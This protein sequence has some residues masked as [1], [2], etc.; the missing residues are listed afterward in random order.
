MKIVDR[1][2]VGHDLDPQAG[3][4]LMPQ[5][6]PL[7]VGVIGMCNGNAACGTCH[8]YVEPSRFAELPLIDEYEEEMLAELDQ[9]APNSRLSCQLV[10]E[11]SMADLTLTVAPRG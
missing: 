4:T 3:S 2:G 6:R 1:D 9:R 10:Y 11:P 7:K 8:V 5:L